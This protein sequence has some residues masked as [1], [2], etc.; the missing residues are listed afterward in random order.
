MQSDGNLVGIGDHMIVGD[1]IAGRID[2]EPRTKGGGLARLSL[3]AAALGHAAVEKVP[4]ELLEWRA[5]RKLRDLGAR[6]FATSAGFQ[7]L[8]RRDVDHRGKKL[9]GEIG[10][11]V[12]C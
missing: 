4:K 12:R 5:R 8:S 3:R 10:E 6:V 9:L 11:T 7:R 1:D 2:D